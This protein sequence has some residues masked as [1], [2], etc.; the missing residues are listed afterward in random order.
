MVSQIVNAA[1]SG[2]RITLFK[3]GEQ[4]RDWIHVDDV[5]EINVAALGITGHNIVNVGTGNP[6]SFNEIVALVNNWQRSLEQTMG[7][8]DGYDI[9]VKYIDCPFAD[10]YQSSTCAST[11]IAEDLFGPR[12]FISLENGVLT[13]LR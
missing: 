7:I 13:L 5:A 9:E 11:Q 3:N 2:N 8:D 12:L 10:A 4:K 6:R 1:K